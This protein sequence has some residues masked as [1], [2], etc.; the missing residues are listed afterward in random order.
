VH[1]IVDRS[2]IASGAPVGEPPVLEPGRNCWRIET[3]PRAS[4]LVDAATFFLRLEQAL[5][6]ATRSIT[7]I[8]W[9]F[10]GRI[11]LRPDC[12]G[13]P[14]LGDFLRT[15]VE[16]RPELHVNIL[17][18]SFATFHAPSAPAELLLG[19]P[20]Q[21]HQRI[22][23]RLDREH[24]FN[25]SHHQKIVCIDE[26][27]A[28]VGGI[29][30]TVDRWDTCD[31]DEVN[32][33]RLLPD[34]NPYR[35]V[36]DVQMVITGDAARSISELARERWRRATG[37]VLPADAGADDLWPDDLA[38]PFTNARIAIARTEP[39]WRNNPAV[40]EI[41]EL[42]VDLIKA[43]RTSIYIEAQ[44]F[45]ARNVRAALRESLSRRHGPEVIVMATRK[46]HSFIERV[47]LGENRDRMVRTLR[48]ADRYNRL[49]VYYPIVAGKD[50]PCDVL[51]H[52][53]VMIVDDRF[54][55]IGSANLNHRSMGLDTECDLVVE[56]TDDA[57]A[58]AVAQVR[59]Q[60]ISEHLGVDP[61]DLDAAVARENSLIRGIDSLNR[62]ERGLR[63][64]PEIN[65]DGPT[66][67][68]FGTGLFDPRHPIE[69]L[70]WRRRAHLRQ[71]VGA[72][73]KAKR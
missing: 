35:P 34:G 7:I 63:P 49:R 18:W 59:T 17:V 46:V 10:D 60:L 69:P 12:D 58:A 72:T 2:R 48:R 1:D 14:S 61:G 56:A 25:A 29:D 5:K 70:W 36:H 20:W 57:S 3:A 31:H 6:K 22:S 50:G 38:P 54:A 52:S 62:G 66:R 32:E 23:L 13:G 65:I 4:V 51:I 47:F 53:K 28:F 8:G 44:Y 41:A 33:C 37:A 24:P 64:Y 27:L 42:T 71:R 67:F 19:A 30:L 73:R 43:A 11:R 45:A 68:H 16:E 40:E 55:R 39:A 26:T 9:D 21:D 15:L